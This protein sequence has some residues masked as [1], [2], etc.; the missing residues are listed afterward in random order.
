MPFDS[1]SGSGGQREPR[2]IS[3]NLFDARQLKH[4]Q[5]GGP[6]YTGTGI[7]NAARRLPPPHEHLNSELLRRLTA[8]PRARPGWHR[9]RDA[10][11][12]RGPL[13]APGGNGEW[14]PFH[15]EGVLSACH[16]RQRRSGLNEQRPRIRCLPAAAPLAAVSMGVAVKARLPREA[17]NKVKRAHPAGACLVW[18]CHQ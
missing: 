14:S 6:A 11:R 5:P 12:I 16:R 10:S 9:R 15:G 3:I 8:I 13:L 18:R 4:D 2:T 17:A 7:Q 1:S